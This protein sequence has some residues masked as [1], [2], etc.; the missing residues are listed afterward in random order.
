MGRRGIWLAALAWIALLC[1]GAT[2]AGATTFAID[3]TE[4]T[5]DRAAGDGMCETSSGA[6]TLRAAVEEANALQGADTVAVPAGAYHLGGLALGL[7]GEIEIR[8]DLTLSGAGARSTVVDRGATP[9]GA[10]IFAVPGALTHVTISDLTVAGGSSAGDG[11]SVAN[12]GVLTLDGVTVRDGKASRGGGIST[13]GVLTITDSTIAANEA[14]A[15]GGG[16][17]VLGGTLTATN[18]TISGNKVLTGGVG[19]VGTG[20]GIS[21]AGGEATLTNVTVAANSTAR[22]HGGAVAGPAA[23]ANTVLA[24]GETTGNCRGTLAGVPASRG[25]NVAD[26]G[27]C[28]LT[29]NGDRPGTDPVLSD[30]QNNNGPTDT[31][32]PRSGSP[33]I[34]A[35][36]PTVCPPT[37]QRGLPRSIGAGCDIGATEYEPVADLALEM[38]DSPDPVPADDQL[39]YTMTVSNLGPDPG[40]GIVL[41][42]ELPPGTVLLAM[43]PGCAALAGVVTCTLDR[44]QAGVTATA[45][46]VVRPE[47]VGAITS[48]ANVTSSSMDPSLTSNVASTAT[49]VLSRM[50]DR[51]PGTAGQ[52]AP[53]PVQGRSIAAQLVRGVLKLRRPGQRKFT[54][55]TGADAI[56]VGSI[57]DASRGTVRLTSATDANGG[58]QTADF[59][60]GVF[61]L[62]QRRDQALTRLRLVGE[63]FKSC[64]RTAS[65]GG[66]AARAAGV[67][68][69]RAAGLARAAAFARDSGKGGRD[70]TSSA[71]KKSAKKEPERHLWGSGKGKYRT[72]GR[73]GSASVRG[74]VWFTQD[75]CNGTR[76]HVRRGVVAV[77]DFARKRTRLVRAGRTVIV[78]PPARR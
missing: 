37:D 40:F 46:V 73:Y 35:A 6:C 57:V 44:L 53:A 1:A 16:I 71:A 76:V 74:T 68:P 67:A 5:N 59:Y 32:L 62:D 3:S 61:R 18:T 75:R 28:A 70:R 36:D 45:A 33:L 7:L 30:L 77:R 10:R 34:D 25:H 72:E 78:R 26:D 31:H 21:A 39:T 54:E 52:P 66:S 17:S 42:Q 41:R 19:S 14:Q 58:T 4:D 55:F 50:F 29:G 23:L 60:G 15:S 51:R 8:D 27:S 69:A 22:N 49:T 56:P 13:T 63:S 43:G 9:F 64:R 24:N 47:T 48:F 2:P 65:G 20:A 11:G 38:S 12:A